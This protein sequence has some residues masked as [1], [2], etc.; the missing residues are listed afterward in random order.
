MENNIKQARIAKGVTQ[1]E[2]ADYLG[3]DRAIISKMENGKHD[4]SGSRLCKVADYLGVSVD[5]LLKR[6]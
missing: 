2:L 5:Y 3:T 4:A 1:V 6:I